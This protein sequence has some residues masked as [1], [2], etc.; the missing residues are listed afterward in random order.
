VI[1]RRG[2][3]AYT[4]LGPIKKVNFANSCQIT[5]THSNAVSRLRWR[6]LRSWG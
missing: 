2:E 5:L 6:I 1:D 4:Q 3:I